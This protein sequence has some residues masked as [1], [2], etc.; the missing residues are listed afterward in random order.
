MGSKMKEDRVLERDLERVYLVKSFDLHFENWRRRATDLQ[1]S[2]KEYVIEPI[3]HLSQEVV[4]AFFSRIET[5]RQLSRFRKD[6]LSLSLHRSQ[7]AC[8]I[9]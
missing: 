2:Y 8:P 4:K 9:L 1:M 3:S 5:R 7:P 6:Y